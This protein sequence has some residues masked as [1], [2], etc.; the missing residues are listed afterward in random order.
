M[1]CRVLPVHTHAMLCLQLDAERAKDLQDQA[2]FNTYQT[3]FDKL[4]V[5]W[6]LG[7]ALSHHSSLLR[8]VSPAAAAAFALEQRATGI[9]DLQKMVNNFI[10]TEDRN[11][12]MFRYI[13]VRGQQERQWRGVHSSGRR[14]HIMCPATSTST[15]K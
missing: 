2:K 4:K 7:S 9:A 5:G 13:Q 12:G 10:E 8:I 6:N 1:R 15:R 14:S 3:A 11:F